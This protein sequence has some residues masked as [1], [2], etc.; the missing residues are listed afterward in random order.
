MTVF[1]TVIPSVAHEDRARRTGHSDSGT[2]VA[3]IFR[4]GWRPELPPSRMRF[5]LR[6]RKREA[7]HDSGPVENEVSGLLASEKAAEIGHLSAAENEARNENEGAGVITVAPQQARR[8]GIVAK[9]S[10]LACCFLDAS[11]CNTCII[12]V[13]CEAA[14]RRCSASLSARFLSRDFS[15]ILPF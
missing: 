9:R 10:Q 11:K 12:M 6:G 2:L 1:R 4:R 7:A 3:S 13:Q 5:R 15:V 8:V 14:G